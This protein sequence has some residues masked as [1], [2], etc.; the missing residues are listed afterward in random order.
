MRFF[1]KKTPAPMAELAVAE[2]TTAMPAAED[3]GMYLYVK[4]KGER[5]WYRMNPSGQLVMT[6]EA[7]AAYALAFTLDEDEIRYPVQSPLTYHN[8]YRLLR[9]ERG[10]NAALINRSKQFGTLYGIEE[11]LAHSFPSTT[12]PLLLLVDKIASEQRARSSEPTVA[13][14]VFGQTGEVGLHALVIGYNNDNTVAIGTLATNMADLGPVLSNAIRL[15]VNAAT[16]KGVPFNPAQVNSNPEQKRLETEFLERSLVRIDVADL[17]AAAADEPGYPREPLL[18]G[19]AL[20]S[21]AKVAISTSATLA[22]LGWGGVLYLSEQI[23]A[24]KSETAQLD[25]V[26]DASQAKVRTA[27]LE[28]IE[29]L[30]TKLTIQPDLMFAA[31]DAVWRKGSRVQLD[32]TLQRAQLNLIVPNIRI[33]MPPGLDRRLTNMATGDEALIEALRTAPPQG[34][35]LNGIETSGDLNAFNVTF[36]NVPVDGGLLDLVGLVNPAGQPAVAA[37]TAAKAA[38]PNSPG[39]LSRQ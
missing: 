22:A 23:K 33:N 26:R 32:A 1:G 21:I 31:A 27:L 36:A 18:R 13:L 37:P 14:V 2:T 35:T 15:M 34:W 17:L 28:R 19:V 4:S 8:G 24:V 38:A 29:G 25:L 6:K 30:S 3:L 20:R 7:P 9:Q 16:L 12:I 5:R 39:R 11:S 10:I